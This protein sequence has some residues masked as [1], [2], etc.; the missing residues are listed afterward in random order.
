[1]NGS[2]SFGVD[3]EV[4][5]VVSEAQVVA[6]FDAVGEAELELDG[7]A[8]SEEPDVIGVVEDMGGGV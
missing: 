2:G 6:G 7:G 8:A 1:M 4:G 5:L 3:A